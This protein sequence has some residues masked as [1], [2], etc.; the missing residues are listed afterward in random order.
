M[1]ETR[2]FSLRPNTVPLTIQT[3][4]GEESFELREMTAANRDKY[5]D[6]VQTRL[7]R[8]QSGKVI[9][10]KRYHEMQSELISLGL[11]RIQ[12]N[13]AALAIP[14]TEIQKWP[15]GLVQ[16]LYEMA[17]KLNKLGEDKGKEVVEEAKKE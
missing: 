12:E 16:E 3:E 1:S 7:V 17:Q 9:T 10:I 2:K 8:D 13:G 6:A 11:V 5:L 14:T 4:K 15:S